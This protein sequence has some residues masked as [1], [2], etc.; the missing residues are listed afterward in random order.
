M[1]IEKIVIF[2]FHCLGFGC[3]IGCLFLESL[4]FINIVRQGA[5]IGIE[6]NPFVQVMELIMTVFTIEYVGWVLYH[7]YKRLLEVNV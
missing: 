3:I 4:V 1:N 7:Y 6:P 5:F 2:L